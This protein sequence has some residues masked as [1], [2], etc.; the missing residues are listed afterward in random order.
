MMLI[1][2]KSK[3]CSALPLIAL[4]LILLASAVAQSQFLEGA[5]HSSFVG[6]VPDAIVVKFDEVATKGIKGQRLFAGRTGVSKIDKLIAKYGVRGIRQQFPRAGQKIYRGRPVD[7]SGWYKLHFNQAVDIAEAVEAFKNSEGVLEAQP[8]GIHAVHPEPNDPAFDDQWHLNQAGSADIHALDAWEIETGNEDIIVAVLDTGV[9][10]FHKDL[11]GSNASYDNPAG[12]NGNMWINR[13]EKDG[14]AGVDDDENGFVDDWIGWDF[15]DSVSNCWTGEDCA[16]ADNDPRDFNGHGT[17]VAGIIATLNN[18]GTDIASTAG[19]WGD[20]VKEDYGNGVKIMPLRIGYS[21][22]SLGV[23]RG[24]VRMDF[25]AEALRYAADNG[26]RLANAS[27]SSDNSG[28]LGESVDYFLAGGGM[29]FK[30]AGNENSTSADY[31][32]GRDDIISVAATDR[33]DCK[34]GFSNYGT[35]VDIS[36][37]GVSIL[38]TDH[39][40]YDPDTD[41]IDYKSGTSMASPLALS[42]AA[43]IWSQNPTWTADT[44]KRQLFN[45]ADPINFAPC[46]GDYTGLMGAGRVNAFNAVFGCGASDSNDDGDTDG[47]DLAD[48]TTNIESGAVDIIDL[49]IFAST[50]GRV[51]CP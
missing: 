9:R 14:E 3:R 29:I 21:A 51:N 12:A 24:F 35:W 25:A 18:N 19:G 28:G 50:F 20:G 16:T 31:L 43:L 27:W 39:N 48:L 46:S 26:A 2:L 47:D 7:L 34:A 37:P 33:S 30:A 32:G 41:E 38:S 42:V 5:D 8:I 10:Y 40:H 11:G 36:A 22:R 1:F 17:H 23:E 49:A 45:S 6:Y 44:V 4:S 13:A 15:I